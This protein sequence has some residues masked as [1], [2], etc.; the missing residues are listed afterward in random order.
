M[1]GCTPYIALHTGKG[2]GMNQENKSIKKIKNKKKER[3]K[4]KKKKETNNKRMED[5]LLGLGERERP[6][7]NPRETKDQRED[8]E[9][10]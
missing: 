2:K 3:A 7:R 9:S 4:K 1:A 6:K 10:R 8:R 5:Q